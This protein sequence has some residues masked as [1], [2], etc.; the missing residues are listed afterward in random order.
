M[1]CPTCNGDGGHHT[2]HTHWEP[3]PACHGVGALLPET[4][5]RAADPSD[6]L[7]ERVERIRAACV[8]AAV[9]PCGR[10]LTPD[11]WEVLTTVLSDVER[12]WD[13]VERRG[14]MVRLLVEHLSG[15]LTDL[16]VFR[17]G[18]RRHREVFEGEGGPE[19]LRLWELLGDDE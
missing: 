16:A 19:D 8:D 4:L 10:D 11:E 15:R 13:E 18:V 17:L 1:T 14:R 5:P 2:T 12:L 7:V 6:T 9:D 3:C